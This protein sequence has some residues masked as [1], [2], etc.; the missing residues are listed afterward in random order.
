MPNNAHPPN[1]E[2]WFD[3][4]ACPYTEQVCRYV[5]HQAVG[6][7]FQNL[8]TDPNIP[9]DYSLYTA[10]YQ[11]HFYDTWQRL[12][13]LGALLPTHAPPPKPILDA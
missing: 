11:S 4:D 13:P 8:H 1:D 10:T 9:Q 3:C 7:M 2:E 6:E 5:T 12:F